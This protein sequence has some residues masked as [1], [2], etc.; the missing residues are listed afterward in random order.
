MKDVHSPAEPK[1]GPSANLDGEEATFSEATYRLRYQTE[2]G[3]WTLKPLGKSS[4]V[5]TD[6]I[7]GPRET[8]VPGGYLKKS[9][10]ARVLLSVLR[11]WKFTLKRGN[12]PSLPNPF[13]WQ[14]PFH[15]R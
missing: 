12:Q 6:I 7:P 5:L 4:T 14:T 1:K 11:D 3:L 10:V 15:T 13:G 8:V 2:K 9:D